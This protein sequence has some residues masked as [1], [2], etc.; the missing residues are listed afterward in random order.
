MALPFRSAM[1]V[2]MTA[3][4][5]CSASTVSNGPGRWVSTV[6]WRHKSVPSSSWP[7]RGGS[8]RTRCTISRAVTGCVLPAK[9]VSPVSATSAW[10][11]TI[12]PVSG[13]TSKDESGAAGHA[14]SLIAA[15]ATRLSLSLRQVTLNRT[16]ARWQVAIAVAS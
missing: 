11:S 16:S 3:W 9:A 4:A 1:T 2:S 14:V 5:R 10:D 15:T 7:W 8:Q 12:S 13:S 6:W